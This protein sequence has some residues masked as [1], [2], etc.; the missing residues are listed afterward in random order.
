MFL[1][2]IIF[3]NL[4]VFIFMIFYISM[5]ESSREFIKLIEEECNIEMVLV[6][7]ILYLVIELYRGYCDVSNYGYVRK[8]LFLNV[9]IYIF[10]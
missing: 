10:V 7:W 8:Y 9:F 2:N 3:D 5:R 1:R 4:L 6:V